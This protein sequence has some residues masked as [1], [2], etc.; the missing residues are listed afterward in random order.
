MANLT[1]FSIPAVSPQPDDKQDG[2]RGLRHIAFDMFARGLGQSDLCLVQGLVLM[3]VL[4]LT[5][6]SLDKATT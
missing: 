3:L 4:M 2:G 1:Q 6:F 5:L